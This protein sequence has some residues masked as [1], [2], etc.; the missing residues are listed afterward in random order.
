MSL[1]NMI[2]QL[3][4]LRLKT[5]MDDEYNDDDLDLGAHIPASFNRVA[6]RKPF[7]ESRSEDITKKVLE[8]KKQLALATRCPKCGGLKE[9]IK[10]GQG[11]FRM[12]CTTCKKNKRRASNTERRQA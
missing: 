2:W 3:L 1:S 4:Q 11:K 6:V 8:E 5:S 7:N 9:K 10:E 12:V